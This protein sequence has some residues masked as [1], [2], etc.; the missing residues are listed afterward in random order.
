MRLE[1]SA[2]VSAALYSK[3]AGP[4][5]D[6]H[7]EDSLRLPAQGSCRCYD[8]QAALSQ[9]LSDSPEAARFQCC[10]SGLGLLAEHAVW[11]AYAA[12]GRR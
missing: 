12:S 6:S 4:P 11:P 2:F 5:R 1:R 7:D 9:N 10:C 8:L 3:G